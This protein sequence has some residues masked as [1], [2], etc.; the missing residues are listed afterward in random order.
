MWAELMREA[1]ATIKND[2]Q[3]IHDLNEQLIN[4]RAELQLLQH[5]I[6]TRD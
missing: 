1:S 3:R 2:G 6:N 4:V 5:V